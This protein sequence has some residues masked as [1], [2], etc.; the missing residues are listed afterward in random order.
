[1]F[2]LL[3]T[4]IRRR[5]KE[6]FPIVLV[7]LIITFFMSGI[8]M[9]QNILNMYIKEQNRENY[10]DWIISSEDGSLDHPYLSNKGFLKCGTYICD[11]QGKSLGLKAGFLDSSLLSFARI[12][13]YEGR[14]PEN[15]T[16]AAADLN[17]LQELGYS[18]DLGQQITVHYSVVD[19]EAEEPEIF[20]KTYT[21]I[22]KTDNLLL[23]LYTICFM[24]QLNRKSI[25]TQKI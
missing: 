10:G 22:I 6:I 11:E 5:K 3:M 17:T 21:I 7:T 15:D 1:M 14:L 25:Y 4:G 19:E 2:S 12:R 9:V 16:E 23:M 18:Y 8:L 24:T 13:L 20:T